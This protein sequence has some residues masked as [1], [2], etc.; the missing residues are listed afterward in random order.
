MATAFLG[1]RLTCRIPVRRAGYS[2]ARLLLLGVSVL[3]V[4][5]GALKLQ[6]P[7]AFA[8]A[9]R[10]HGLVPDGM[11]FMAVWAVA[12]AE[13]VCGTL[14][15]W[16]ALR[17]RWVGTRLGAILCSTVFFAFTVYAI[18]LVVDPPPVPVPCGCIAANVEVQSW[19]PIAARNGLIA[20]VLSAIGMLREPLRA[21][22]V[23]APEVG[24]PVD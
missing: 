13:L 11:I 15:V 6:D 9:L 17:R 20:S 12:V 18:G 14:G 19:W 23:A 21:T 1:Q 10:S 8:F 24:N 5:T 16:C 2:A 7:E 3:F 4:V 22:P